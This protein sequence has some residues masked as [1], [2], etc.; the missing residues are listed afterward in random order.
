MGAGGASHKQ[1]LK[2][3]GTKNPADVLTKHVPADLLERHLEA[4]G[5]AATDGRAAAAPELN[6]LEAVLFLRDAPHECHGEL[7]ISARSRQGPESRAPRRWRA[8]DRQAPRG[9]GLPRSGG[10]AGF[11]RFGS[12]FPE[13]GTGSCLPRHSP[14]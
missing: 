4:T 5:M 12:G 7:P 3:L 10:G 9:R 2:V 13:F 1:Y 11:L 8:A 14:R 6:T